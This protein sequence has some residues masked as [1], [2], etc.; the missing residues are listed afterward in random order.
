MNIQVALTSVAAFVPIVLLVALI[1]GVW[2]LDSQDPIDTNTDITY[3]E[4]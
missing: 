2:Y 4:E 3:Y 1:V